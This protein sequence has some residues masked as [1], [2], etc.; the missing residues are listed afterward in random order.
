L[1]PA[2]A[3]L[4]HGGFLLFT[5]PRYFHRGEVCRHSNF[6]KLQA[7]ARGLW[8]VTYD[9]LLDQLIRRHGK[10]S[11]TRQMIQVLSLIKLHGHQRVQAAVEQ[12]LSLGCSDAA[13]IRHLVQAVDLAHARSAIADLGVLS[14]FEAP[15]PVITDYDGLL[16]Q[17][18]AP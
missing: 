11:G 12:A 18:V 8:T 14:R 15:L 9:H 2:L 13:A 6:N 4:S 1:D 7:I 16:G 3:S 17:E 5:A 10:Q